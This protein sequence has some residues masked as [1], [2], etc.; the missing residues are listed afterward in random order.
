M[1]ANNKYGWELTMGRK[2]GWEL[3]MAK[4]LAFCQKFTDVST[5]TVMRFIN[6]LSTPKYSPV[7]GKKQ[8][9]L[10]N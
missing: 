8:Y 6:G 3:T 2:Y 10:T 5:S 4:P 1:R 9:A 7:F